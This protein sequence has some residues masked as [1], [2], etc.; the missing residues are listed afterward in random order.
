MGILQGQDLYREVRLGGIVPAG[1]P[2]MTAKN[3]ANSF[4][5]P[6]E[7]PV[8]LHGLNEIERTARLKAATSAE[9]RT[10]RPSIK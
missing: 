2:G 5:R 6:D 7:R 10:D 1:M 8:L 4:P 3:S 9:H